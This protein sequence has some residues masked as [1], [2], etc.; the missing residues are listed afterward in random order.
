MFV[1]K[2]EEVVGGWRKVHTLY[3]APNIRVIKSRK[4]CAR[5][6]AHMGEM[7]NAYRIFIRKPEGKTLL[8][9]PRHGSEDNTKLKRTWCHNVE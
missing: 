8:R 5:H 6:V 7:R 4:R 9:K 3:F 1:P 2:M